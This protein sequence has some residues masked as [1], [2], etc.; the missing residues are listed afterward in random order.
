MVLFHGTE[1][2][3]PTGK[4]NSSRQSFSCIELELLM[5]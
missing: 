2:N 5:A 4:S 1:M 3:S